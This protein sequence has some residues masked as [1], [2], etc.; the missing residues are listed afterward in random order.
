MAFRDRSEEILEYLKVHGT[1]TVETLARTLYVSEATIRRDL[2]EMKKLGRIER[3]HGG[4]FLTEN[5]DEMSIY[6]RRTKNAKEKLRA[7]ELAIKSLP[8]FQTVFIDNSST[9]LALAERLNFSHKTVITNGVQVALSVSKNS[10]VTLICPGGEIR[11]NSTAFMGTM[12][13]NALH[14]FKFDL[15]LLSCSAVDAEGSY[16]FSVDSMQIK[17]VAMDKSK[18]RVLIFDR[19]KLDLTAPCRTAPL[20]DY[21]L[22]VTEAPDEALVALRAVHPNVQNS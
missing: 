8:E 12:T 10:D 14:N 21:D 19:T 15:A 20:S 22:I 11:Y 18:K 16:E 17:R 3:S 13:V 6:V 9:C 4:A 7:T 5:S 1:A 2:N